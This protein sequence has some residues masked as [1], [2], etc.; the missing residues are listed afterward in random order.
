MNNWISVKDKLPVEIEK[1]YLVT[2]GEN[3]DVYWWKKLRTKEKWI[4]NDRDE[5][6]DFNVTHWMPLPELPDET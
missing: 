1:D 4:W 3:I 2:D 6:F 5:F